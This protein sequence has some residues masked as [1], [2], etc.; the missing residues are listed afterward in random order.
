MGRYERSSII[1]APVERVFAF[2]ERPDA[3]RL[4]TPAWLLPRVE[5]L[6]GE[7]LEAGVELVVT[8]LLGPWHAMHT[9]YVRDRLFVD[10]IVS[11]PFNRWRHEHRFEPLGNRTRLTDSMTFEHKFAPEWAVKPGLAMLFAYRHRVTRE[12]CERR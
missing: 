7:G 6:R 1:D 10:E 5:R 4:L 9:A 3:V 11:G 12:H 2:H 8:T